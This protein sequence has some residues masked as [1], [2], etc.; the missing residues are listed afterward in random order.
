MPA[1]PPSA[2]DIAGDVAL[3]AAIAARDKAAF[4]ALFERYAG[5]IKAFVMRA[6]ASPQDADEI[7]QDVMVAIWRSA[8]GYDPARAAPATWIYAI[9]RNRRIDLLRRARRPAPDPNDPLFQPDP[10]PDSLDI[11]SHAEAAARIRA[12]LA[13]LSPE[14]RAVLVAAFYGGQ[15]HS[16][17]A[18]AT[19]LPPGT[20]KSRMR[21]A[22]RRLRDVLGDEAGAEFEY[23]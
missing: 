8:G 21:L 1:L 5:R 12:T 13:T 17:I 7:T 11:L 10:E 14:Q 20:V 6:G 9:A 19:G 23:D 18:S 3:L 2:S 22:F 15:T 4:T 16:E